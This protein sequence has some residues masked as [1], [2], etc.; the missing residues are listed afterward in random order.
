MFTIQLATIGFTRK[1]AQQFF[2]LLAG[3][4]IDLLVD[5]RLKPNSQLSGFARGH[6]LPFLLDRLNGCGYVH[7]PAFAPTAVLL[8]QYRDDDDWAQYETGYRAL[9]HERQA[10]I[11]AAEWWASHRTCL[12]CSEHTPDRCHRRLAAE[13]LAAV[14]PGVIITHL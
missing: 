3:S 12:L 2:E 7:L 10:D 4:Q 11:P 14:W 5:T 1:T 6:D 9:L 13:Y 8:D